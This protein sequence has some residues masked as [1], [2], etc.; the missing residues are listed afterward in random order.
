MT[1]RVLDPHAQE[2]LIE[3][4]HATP[5]GVLRMSDKMPGL[6]TKSTNMGIMSLR[7]GQLGVTSLM[8][9]SV[10]SELQDVHQMMAIVWELGEVEPEFSGLYSAWQPNP[11]SPI[12]LLME[13][14]YQNLYGQQPR[15]TAI[16][17]GLEVGVIT[18]TYPDIDAI[19]LGS[20]L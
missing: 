3:A 12:V 20:T 15:L 17:A 5:Q 11:N 16:H 4:L 14:A 2:V 8:R 9:S 18:S 19:S 10:D 13:S 7:D 6:V 1:D